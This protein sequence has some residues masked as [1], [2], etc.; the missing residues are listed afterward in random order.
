MVNTLI[1]IPLMYLI[2]IHSKNCL[3]KKSVINPESFEKDINSVDDSI[4]FDTNNESDEISL[5]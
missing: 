4:L 3:K 5:L 1:M 2:I